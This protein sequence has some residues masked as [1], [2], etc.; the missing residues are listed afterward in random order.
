MHTTTTPSPSDAR[1]AAA[2]AGALDAADPLAFYRSAFRI[3]GPEPIYMDGNSLGR[4]PERTAERAQQVINEEWGQR[5]VRGWGE[6][7]DWYGAPARIGDKIGGLLGAAPGQVVVC[8]STSLNLYKLAMAALALRPGRAR[9]LTD[10]ANFPSDLYILQGCLATLDGAGG[11]QHTILR[12]DSPDADTAAV[13]EAID[14]DTALVTL[15]LV[16]FKSGALYDA[17]AITRRAHEAGAL[18]LWD[19]S[20]AAGAVPL[21]LDEWG[22]D[23]AVGCTYKYLNGGPGAP[24]FL[25][26]RA[27]LQDQALSPVWGWFGEAQPFAFD[28][29]YRP[30]PG[31]RRFQCGTPPMLSLLAIEPGVDLLLEAGMAALREKSVRQTDYLIAL[32]DHFLTPLGFSVATPRDQA[33]RGS[34][35]TLRHPEGY[36]INRA[37]IEELGVIPDFREP[38]N[39]R[40]GIAPIYTTY[41]EIY[42]TVKRLACVVEEGRYEKYAS[43][44]TAVT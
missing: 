33:R 1:F 11:Q 8:D 23:F 7:T 16:V 40:L 28:L 2:L 15:S 10:T 21:A 9:V 13:L 43:G 20:H 14:E 34:H 35:V 5:L 41:L 24:A 44:R 12:V 6:D 27:D 17:A 22:V 32:A 25:Y 19:L 26:V 38:D 37:L 42:E 36:R 39:I 30:A 29:D 3:A 31:I 18:V 4:L